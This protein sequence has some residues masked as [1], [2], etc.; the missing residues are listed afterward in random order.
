MTGHR[1]LPPVGSFKSGFLASLPIMLGYAPMAFSFGIVGTQAGLSA[2]ETSFI[3]IL[4][5]AG[6]AQFVLA[7]MWALGTGLGTI[8]IAVWLLN[9]RHLFYGPALLTQLTKAPNQLKPILA[10]GLTDEVFASAMA[11]AEQQPLPPQWVIGMGLGAY[12]AWV[13][14]TVAGAWLGA[15]F[16]VQHAILA[17]ALNFV[18]PAL[19]LALLVQSAWQKRW[20]VILIAAVVAG[21]LSFFLPLHVAMLSGMITGAIVQPL[22]ANRLTP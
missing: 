6:A 13:G 22:C 15:N 17:P 1:R 10:F 8:L 9:V 7:S 2:F 12:S 11:K 19:F 18:L 21:V 16:G 3:S 4:I 5:F 14:G 20:P